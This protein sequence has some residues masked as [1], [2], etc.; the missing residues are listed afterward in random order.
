MTI[1]ICIDMPDLYSIL[2][3]ILC[4]EVLLFIG[5]IG[6]VAADIDV[7]AMFSCMR[8]RILCVYYSSS[9]YWYSK[10]KIEI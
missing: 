6:G 2:I 3:K 4:D 8:E 1:Q 10:T 5:M 7:S 9:Q